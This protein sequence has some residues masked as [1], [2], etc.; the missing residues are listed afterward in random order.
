MLVQKSRDLIVYIH[1]YPY[2][3]LHFRISLADIIALKKHIS[4]LLP[5]SL[6]SKESQDDLREVFLFLPASGFQLPA[7]IIQQGSCCPITLNLF[8][9]MSLSSTEA[10]F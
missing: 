8:F 2:L 6:Y 3:L 7:I 9:S 1:F 4:H 5:E 10:G